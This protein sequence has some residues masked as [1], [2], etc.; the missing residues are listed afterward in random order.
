M[1]T[2]VQKR[3]FEFNLITLNTEVLLK[4]DSLNL[5]IEIIINN[6]KEEKDTICILQDNANPNNGKFVQGNSIC[7]IKLTEDK[8]NNTE[9]DRIRIFPENE[10]INGVKDLDDVLYNPKRTDEAFQKIKLKKQ[11]GEEIT[12]LENI[13]YY[14]EEEVKIIP[15]NNIESIIIEKC[16]SFGKF[17]L[18]GSFSE[19]ITKSMKFDF[20]LTYSSNEVKCEFDKAVKGEKIEMICKLH[21]SFE[22]VESIL[23]EQKLIRK[24]YKE[25]FII[26]KKNSNLQK[27]LKKK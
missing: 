14:L 16:S 20:V 18:I 4:G 8:Y 5:K 22:L 9:F 19:D 23:I 11:K 7:T 15:I 25:I 21:S 2:N 27:I 13:V 24:K 17:T 3:S 6:I 12:D 26:Q 1:Q 10:E